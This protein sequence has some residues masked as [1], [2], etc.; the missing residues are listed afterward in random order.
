MARPVTLFTGQW[1]DMKLEDLARKA[2]KWGYDGLELACWGDHFEVDKALSDAGYTARKREELEKHDLQVFAISNH[3]VGQAVLD[4]ID[5]RHKAILP[6]YVWGDG[7]PDGVRHRA[8]E[9]MKNTAR[10]AQKLG[11]EVVNGFTG[12]SIWHLLYSF[13]PTPAEDID[14]G[15]DLLAEAWNPILDVFQE[16]GVK[17]GLEVHPT[18][19]AFDLYSAERALKVLDHREEFGFN[20]DPSHL[21]W[22]GVD[23]V[24]FIRA[25]P[26]RIYH[27]HV[28]DAIV[29]LN[30]RAGILASHLG[31]GDPRRGWD[32]R[33]PG[34]G[35]VN[36]EE[37][38][39]ALNAANYEGPLSIEWEDSGMD[40]EHGA[41]EAC[42]F[43]KKIDFQPS[44]LAFDAAFGD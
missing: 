12:S 18:E 28:K 40:R 26:D 14:A 37:I 42:E 10:A 29:T 43:T 15:F 36:F 31:F 1:A 33:S 13:P 41:A 17:F 39:R 38:I 16:C 25:F 21:L 11:V 6:P 44:K 24:E 20:F 23:P 30:G 34:R 2:R 19:I 8:A 7:D 5:H 4:R 32:F 27:V 35:G 3:L 22:Q 9:E